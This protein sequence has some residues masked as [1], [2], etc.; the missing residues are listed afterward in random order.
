MKY[1][2]T[3]IRFW[4][5]ADALKSCNESVSVSTLKEKERDYKYYS[6]DSNVELA[7]S[8]LW[9]AQIYPFLQTTIKGAIWYQG[10]SD[11]NEPYAVE[12]ACMFPAMI[13]DWRQKWAQNRYN[14]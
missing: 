9:N 1:G 5:S 12:Y 7:D 11:A 8:Q 4:S 10:E 3:P 2:G 6:G 13:A 14:T